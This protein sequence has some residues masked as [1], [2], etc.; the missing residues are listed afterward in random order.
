[1]RVKFEAV[2]KLYVVCLVALLVW[3][4]WAAAA[5]PTNNVPP[6]PE[7]TN[8][9]GG[10]ISTN[11]S[12]DFGLKRVEALQ[13]TFLGVP[14][15]QYLASLIYIVLAVVMSR[16]LDWFIRG[17]LRHW[18]SKTKT[19]FDDI[20][21]QLLGGP[22]KI[23]A[24]V[25]LLHIGLQLFPW[26]ATVEVYISRILRVVIA[27]SLTYVALRVVDVLVDYWRQRAAAAGDRGLSDQLL[28]FIRA[29]LKVFIAIVAVLLTCETLGLPMK[30]LLASLSVGG[31][32]LGLAAQDTLANLFGAVAVFVDKPF[33]VG[34]AIK[35]EAVEGTVEAIGMRSTRVRTPDGHLVAVPNKTVANATVTNI[36]KRSSIRTVMNLGLT[37][38][39]SAER[40]QR[41]IDLLT[42]IYKSHPMTKD[43][44]ITFN[45][46]ADSAL[47]IEVVHFWN[48][49]DH[50]AYL[51]G[52][53][54]L[55][56]QVK[57]RF[58]AEKL[59][60]AYP[61]RMLYVKSVD[62]AS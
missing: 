33:R 18:A 52:L 41:A 20:L 48:S 12:L 31:L 17:K 13:A 4:M 37:Y 19:Q 16:L 23:I 36:A 50:R 40:V 24:L 15:W 39:T 26:P 14:V 45:R 3:T 59:E 28:P 54:D 53:Q 57:Q 35:I 58:D 1:M 47:N 27:I 43:V 49:T 44:I 6:P 60:F 55:N 2:F 29:A 30:G 32:A 22:I 7:R 10:L 62:T 61:T 51:V 9:L 38:D 21:I 25:I 8:V 46:F 42:E 11:V 34:D 5:E 56:L